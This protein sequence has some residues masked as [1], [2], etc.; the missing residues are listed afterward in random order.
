MGC[1]H[2]FYQKNFLNYLAK[3]FEKIKKK[4][5]HKKFHFLGHFLVSK[6]PTLHTSAPILVANQ[7]SDLWPSF[8]QKAFLK[9]FSKKNQKNQKIQK[10]TLKMPFF[11]LTHQLYTLACQFW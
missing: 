4:K 2:L 8:I 9:I 11:S 1:G 5:K 10:N 3:K 7:P 6:S